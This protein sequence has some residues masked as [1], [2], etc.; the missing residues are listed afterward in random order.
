MAWLA[1]S[2]VLVP[3]S[4][5]WAIN[6][7]CIP[8]CPQHQQHQQRQAVINGMVVFYRTTINDLLTLVVSYFI[9][10]PRAVVFRLA[11]ILWVACLKLLG[12][13]FC[14]AI[15]VFLKVVVH[16]VK[17]R[18]KDG[19]HQ[20]FYC[21]PRGMGTDPFFTTSD[22]RAEVHE[23]LTLITSGKERM[24][25]LCF[26][27]INHQP[28]LWRRLSTHQVLDCGIMILGWTISKF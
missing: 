16:A 6:E 8:W 3:S 1:C 21:T 23:P 9:S 19:Y 15:S 24:M 2:N 22:F 26:S 18:Q 10:N 14:I 27:T 5:S 17:D 25:I 20:S 4:L 7:S 13:C 28:P 12:V 11:C